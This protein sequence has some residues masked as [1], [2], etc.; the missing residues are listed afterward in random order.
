MSAQQLA[1]AAGIVASVLLV[2]AVMIAITLIVVA[3][4]VAIT[5]IIRRA[6]GLGHSLHQPQRPRRGRRDTD[7]HA[8]VQR[9][10]WTLAN[11]IS[12]DPPQEGGC[13]YCGYANCDYPG[14]TGPGTW[15]ANR[16]PAWDLGHLIVSASQGTDRG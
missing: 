4:T 5:L 11:Y 8:D 9:H 12:P 15:T 2:V 10:I 6:A 13:W 7:E 14:R 3:V 1:G 16:D